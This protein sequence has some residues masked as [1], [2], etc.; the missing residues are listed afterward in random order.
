MQVSH[1]EDH[2]THAVIGG[3]EQINF[4]ISESAEFFHILSS[5]LYSDQILAVVRET[6][7]NAWDAHID[8]G[9]TDTPIEI[10]LVEGKFT[11]KD[12]GL[13]I[14]K[15]MMGPIYAVYGGSTKK[16]NGKATGG[17]G[18][19]CK[20]PFA[21]TDHFDVTSCHG[22]IK[23]IYNLSKSSGEMGGKPGI[24]TIVSVPTEETG[25]TVGINI[26]DRVDQ[27]RFMV[28]IKRIVQNAEIL[29]TLNGEPM[30]T[31]AFSA[32]VNGFAMVA[33]NL[34]EQHSMLCIRY[35]NVIYPVERHVAFSEMY[36]EAGQ[37]MQHLSHRVSLQLVLQA[38]PHSI[39]VTPSRES[40]SMQDKTIATV[41]EL[42]SKF[43][44]HH[45][46]GF[47]K[48]CLML[49]RKKTDE[50]IAKK[51]PDKLLSKPYENNLMS[52]D[53]HGRKSVSF[54][55][56]TRTAAASSMGSKY[57]EYS[58]F[59]KKDMLYR[60]TA[61]I[62]NKT[63]DPQ[64]LKSFRSTLKRQPANGIVASRVEGW[65]HKNITWPL[66]KG[67]LGNPDMDGN[68]LFVYGKS[69][70]IGLFSTYNADVCSIG[71]FHPDSML[72]CLPF[73]RKLVVL[74]HS[75]N[76][77]ESRLHRM[78]D[79]VH[80]ERSGLLVYVVPRTTKRVEA[81]R[82]F[83]SEQAVTLVDMTNVLEIQ[84][85]RAT[86]Y[87]PK[88]KRAEGYATLTSSVKGIRFSQDF[89]KQEDATRIVKPLFYTR[90]HAQSSK[91]HST[92][93]LPDM[94]RFMAHYLR[95]HW[96]DKGAVIFTTQ[97][98]EKFRK[99]DVPCALAF[100]RKQV[101][102]MVNDKEIGKYLSFSAQKI[103]QHLLELGCE[104][105]TKSSYV[106]LIVQNKALLDTLKLGAVLPPQKFNLVE[107]YARLTTDRYGR[108]RY[109]DVCA[110]VKTIAI[111]SKAKKV[112]ELIA[113]SQLLPMLD[114][115]ALIKRL[116]SKDQAVV[117]QAIN[118]FIK[119]LKGKV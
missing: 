19:G 66:K 37:L 92:S 29:A 35:G 113:S 34:L 117:D 73:L 38:P 93:D 4:G 84:K 77:I 95:D 5:T 96:G 45:H 80:G 72:N 2:V 10:T 118:F 46:S 57:P 65:F 36:D 43:L 1:K 90:L 14:A 102:D 25:L 109:A 97:Q 48:E 116:E 67:M 32:A 68:R 26:K 47:Q 81:A 108:E 61:L 11:I 104:K 51:V 82:K 103:E 17:F 76:N 59:R 22:G 39:S 107:L 41:V 30:N 99:E 94:P 9:R 3:G 78:P 40:L 106:N 12:F 7:C 16:N 54:I 13:G 112:A 23:T 110:W 70:D 20:S 111:S 115:A 24:K 18:L 6:L 28:L 101:C 55:T 52:L 53:V 74:T 83:F 114:D 87:V 79:W 27:Q 75:R 86:S 44:R 91:N 89:A 119:A 88:A 69:G 31:Y 85:P 42:L 60:L 64:L 63:Y 62:D 98:E 56:D 50:L 105:F 15:D 58:G 33:G 49:V 8:A 71:A 21:Y 100:A